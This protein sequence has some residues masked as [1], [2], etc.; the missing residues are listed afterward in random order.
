VCVSEVEDWDFRGSWFASALVSH[1]AVRWI[2]CFPAGKRD[3]E[4]RRRSLPR[5]TAMTCSTPSPASPA[6][7]RTGRLSRLS[8]NWRV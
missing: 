4:S 1:E 2:L 7:P 5:R 3:W 8:Q 6:P